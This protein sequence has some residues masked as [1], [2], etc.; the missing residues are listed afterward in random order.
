MMGN[1]KQFPTIGCCGIDCGLCPRFYGGSKSQCPGCG[2]PNFELKHP[3]CGVL[4]CC[5]K[6]GIESCGLC[7]E[8]DTCQKFAPK[9]KKDTFVTV[10]PAFNNLSIIHQKSL[11]K[12]IDSQQIR[13]DL[14]KCLFDNFNDGRSKNFFCLAT[15]LLP[16]SEIQQIFEKLQQMLANPKDLPVDNNERVTYIKKIIQNRADDLKIALKMRK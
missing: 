9:I 13:I 10:I 6:K 4:N 12:F 8:M 7:S 15:A 3:S 2:G 5:I 1:L 11:P 14:L 16:I